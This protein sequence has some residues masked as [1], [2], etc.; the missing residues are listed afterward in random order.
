M[1]NGLKILQ[2]STFSHELVKLL[3]VKNL[4]HFYTHLSYCNKLGE[5]HAALQ[6]KLSG[7]YSYPSAQ[8]MHSI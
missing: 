5:E 1:L 3:S 7:S 4:S 8:R 2:S 6:I